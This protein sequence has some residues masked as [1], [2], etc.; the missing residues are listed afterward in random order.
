MS[1]DDF[2]SDGRPE[3][4]ADVDVREPRRFKVLLHND[5]YTTMEFV[6]DILRTVFRK[7]SEQAMAITASVHEKGLGVCGVYT[8]EVAETKVAQV[9][10][11]ARRHQH[12]LQCTMEKD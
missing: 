8:D 5:D 4:G 3:L 9:V 10:E 12:P 1:S 7:T 11:T 6:V 2:Q